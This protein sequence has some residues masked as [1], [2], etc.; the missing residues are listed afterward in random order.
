VAEKMVFALASQP[1]DNLLKMK[2]KAMAFL[3]ANGYTETMNNSLTKLQYYEQFL[4][5]EN[6][7]L[8]QILNPLSQD[9]GV[10]RQ[11]LI[12]GG[13]EVVER[14]MNRQQSSIKIF[15]FGATYFKN[16]QGDYEE[17][18]QLML[19]LSGNQNNE[20]WQGKARTATFF[21]LKGVLIAMLNAMG[22]VNLTEQITQHP[23]LGE[24][25][26][27]LAGTKVV[28]EIGTVSGPIREHFDV[29]QDVFVAVI[30]WPLA[31]K[32]AAKRKFVFQEMPRFP[33]V[34]RD[35]ALLLD[36]DVK[37]EGLRQAAIKAGGK[38]LKEVNLF[39]EYTGKNLPE[40]KKSYAL[41]FVLQDPEQTLTDKRVE[42]IM[43]R[44]LSAFEKQ[45]AAVLR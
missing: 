13:M 19:M 11:S 41:S 6:G 15:E 25:L 4:K 24:C 31:V 44:I 28:A 42:E 35:L 32:V 43:A 40:G 38:L 21:D 27:L 8:V 33:K 20:S 36:K 37:Y 39:D 2:P 17:N 26:S 7:R 23:L 22:V 30:N 3:T 10:M 16:G 34:R 1:K 18:A 14:N 5:D 12:F 45:F 29:R 9:L